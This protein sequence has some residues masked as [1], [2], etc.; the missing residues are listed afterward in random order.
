MMRGIVVVALTFALTVVLLSDSEATAGNKTKTTPADTKGDPPPNT[1]GNPPPD[2]A[3]TP[4][5]A[6]QVTSPPEI[7]LTGSTGSGRTQPIPHNTHKGTMTTPH[8]VKKNPSTKKG[9]LRIRKAD[10]QTLSD[11]L[12]DRRISAQTNSDI[13]QGKM[14]RTD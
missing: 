13:Q 2:P 4:P 10:K 11:K 12:T 7:K 14:K 5:P 6:N 3:T 9:K 1:P 8:P